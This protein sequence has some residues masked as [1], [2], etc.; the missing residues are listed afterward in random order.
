MCFPRINPHGEKNGHN[1][2]SPL[3]ASEGT[4]EGEGVW[5]DGRRAKGAAGE[6]RKAEGGGRGRGH[7]APAP[8]RRPRRKARPAGAPK[9]RAPKGAPKTGQGP[10][11]KGPR[12]KRGEEAEGGGGGPAAS[13]AAG[14]EP[15]APDRPPQRGAREGAFQAHSK[16]TPWAHQAHTVAAWGAR[17]PIYFPPPP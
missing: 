3:G 15:P 8:A 6:P 5:R 4:G 13:K 16:R 14:G 7:R 10:R 2:F 17:R 11:R 9:R 12:A 1:L